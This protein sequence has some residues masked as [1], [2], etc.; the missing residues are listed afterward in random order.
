MPEAEADRRARHGLRDTRILG[1][2]GGGVA[3]EGAEGLTVDPTGSVGAGLGSITPIIHKRYYFPKGN[4]WWARWDL[5][6][7]GRETNGF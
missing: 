7:Q 3:E 4:T 1:G 5:N 6:P 2:G